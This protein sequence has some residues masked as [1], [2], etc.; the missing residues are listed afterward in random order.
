[1]LYSFGSIANDGA[2]PQAALAL[3]GSTLYGTTAVGGVYSGPFSNNG[4]IFSINTNGGGYNVLYNFGS[5]PQD[6]AYPGII[7][8][9]GS[10]LYGTTQ[11]GGK[12]G[13]PL[14]SGGN[15]IVYTIGTSGGGYNVL[16]NFGTNPNDG[17][18]PQ[19]LVISGSTLYGTNPSTLF[20]VGTNGGGYNVLYSSASNYP[21]FNPIILG[22]TLYVT[23]AYGGNTSSAPCFLSTPTAAATTC[24]KTSGSIHTA[25]SLCHPSRFQGIPFTARQSMAVQTA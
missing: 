16:Y 14:G 25:N 13:G 3:S 4:I 7:L 1:M 5:I 18:A 22:S 23:T 24:C 12:Y 21:W 2:R 10:K 11:R 15:G 6:G 17:A 20:T 9:S 8:L 19:G